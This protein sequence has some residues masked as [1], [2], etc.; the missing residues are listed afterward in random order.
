MGLP[1]LPKY[2]FKGLIATNQ[3]VVAAARQ[4]RGLVAVTIRGSVLFYSSAI[5]RPDFHLSKQSSGIYTESIR[6]NLE[7]YTTFEKCAV[8]ITDIEK[9]QKVKVNRK[10]ASFVD[11]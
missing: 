9:I 10:D 5:W 1:C 8:I 7:P 4:Q 2:L 11:I 3:L 6:S